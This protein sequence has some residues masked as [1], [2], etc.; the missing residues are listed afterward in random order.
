LREP[1]EEGTEPNF[2]EEEAMEADPS[3]DD[4]PL[5]LPWRLLPFWDNDPADAEVRTEKR[6]EAYC[7]SVGGGL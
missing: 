1:A 7:G 5:L 6:S 2:R 4:R 3:K